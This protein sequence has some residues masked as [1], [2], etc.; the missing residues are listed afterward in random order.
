MRTPI[1]LLVA[2]LSITGCTKTNI[3]VTESGM[4]YEILKEGTGP[5]PKRGDSVT[6]H[7]TGWLEDGTK[8][9]SSVD[10]NQP[11]T[12]K[13]GVGQVIQGW[14]DGVATMKVGGKSKFFIPPELGYGSRGAGG[15]IPPNAKLIFEVELLSIK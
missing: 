1:L 9:D 4:K 5:S 2:A 11:F 6:V 8:F 10:R 3:G 13:L 15:I 7:Y 14:D 12:F